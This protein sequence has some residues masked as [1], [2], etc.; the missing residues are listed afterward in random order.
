MSYKYL[1]Y[2][3]DEGIGKITIN[4]PEVLNALSP[5]LFEELI[6]AFED[7]GKDDRVRVIVLTGAGRAFSAGVDLVALG[8][9]S[10]DGGR[11]GALLDDPAR[12]LIH[13]MQ[14]VPKVVI[15]AVNGHCFTGALELMLGCDLVVVAN[16][17]RLGDTHAKFGLRPSWGMSQRLPRLIGLLKAKELSFTAG[18]ITGEE[19]AR[20]GLANMAVPA[21]ELE[22][23]VQEL[24]G[25]IMENSPEALAAAKY[26]FNEGAKGSLERGL[27]LEARSEFRIGDTEDRGRQFR[28]R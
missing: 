24:A 22:S 11:V 15:A 16:E 7:A 4:R 9:S 26:L 3:I 27:D 6:V 18:A 10:L 1:D 20:I 13:V 23:R 17:A 2:E 25:K 19:A 21:G 8:E 5:A 12:Q 28:K 14:T